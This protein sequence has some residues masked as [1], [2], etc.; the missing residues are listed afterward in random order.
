VRIDDLDVRVACRDAV[1]DQLHDR[2]RVLDW[3]ADHPGEVVVGDQ[4][5]AG[6]VA[7]RVQVQH[8][9][10]AVELGEDRVVIGIDQRAPEHGGVHGNPGH[11]QLAQSPV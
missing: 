8:R 11:A 2:D 5:R 3:R 1:R 4:R 7:S 10:P 9:V 6:A